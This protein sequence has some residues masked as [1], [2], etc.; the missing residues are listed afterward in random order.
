MRH[1]DVMK[2]NFVRAGQIEGKGLRASSIHKYSVR[3]LS[4]PAF[5]PPCLISGR[6]NGSSIPAGPVERDIS[7]RR[8]FAALI[9]KDQDVVAKYNENIAQL[10]SIT[11]L[12]GFLVTKDVRI[13]P[14]R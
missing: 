1:H 6:L 9:T 5:R 10:L 14:Q 3:V 4:Y 11:A 13:T 7:R 12:P 8:K 2:S